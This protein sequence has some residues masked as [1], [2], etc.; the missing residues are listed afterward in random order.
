MTPEQVA[1]VALGS[2]A[3]LEAEQAL[4]RAVEVLD[5]TLELVGLG[6]LRP[7][8]AASMEQLRAT[9]DTIGQRVQVELV[10]QLDPATFGKGG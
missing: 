8:L 3:T 6:D 10:P 2:I 7:A 4:I 9:I 5:G 1:R